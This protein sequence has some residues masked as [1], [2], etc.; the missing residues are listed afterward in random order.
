MEGRIIKVLLY[1][2]V[3]TSVFNWE[4]VEIITLPVSELLNF[5]PY[6]LPEKHGYLLG[7]YC[8]VATSDKHVFDS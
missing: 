4:C 5:L 1:C 3:A 8:V 6:G 7:V 2:L